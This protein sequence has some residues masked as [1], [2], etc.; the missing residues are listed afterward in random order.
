MVGSQGAKPSENY[1]LPRLSLQAKPPF[2]GGQSVGD[3]R[4]DHASVRVW[5]L[6]GL[7]HRET[8]LLLWQRLPVRRGGSA[9]R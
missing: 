5:S 2:T 8:P 3:P 6:A 7:T 9:C 1:R 4:T